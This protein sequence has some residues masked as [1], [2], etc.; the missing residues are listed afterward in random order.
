M[1]VFF[2]QKYPALKNKCYVKLL[3]SQLLSQSGGYIQNVALSALITEMTGSRSSLG[4]FLCVS[5]APVFLFSYFAGELTRKIHAKSMLVATELMLFIM[6]AALIFMSGIPFWGFLVFG[7]VW[8]TVRAFQTPAAGSMPKLLCEKAELSSGVAAYSLVLSLSR[9]I[10]PIISGVLYVSFS[11]RVAFAANALSYIPSIFLLLRIK[12]SSETDKTGRREKAKMK[13]S[14]PLL[15]VVFAVSLVGTAYNIIFTGLSEKLG[16]SRIWFSVFMAL[17][18]LGSVLGAYIMSSHKKMLWAALGIS[19]AA[20]TLALS[21]RVLTIC[22]VVVL[23]GLCDYLF[24]TS[25]LTRIQEENDERSIVGAMGAYT[26]VT[27]GALPLG[28]LALGFLTQALSI[29]AV[30]GIIAAFIAG[31]YLILYRKIR[32]ST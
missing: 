20:G 30:L 11:Y 15:L 16:L 19:A 14:M 5:Y 24:F 10:G 32:F 31:I 7:A 21:D 28:F 27:T 9:A 2:I 3:I 23:Y 26:I 13:L 1:N 8:G 17:V 6:S 29:S 18:G 4:I 25:A 22:P 12:A